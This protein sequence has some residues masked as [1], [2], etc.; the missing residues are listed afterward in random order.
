MTPVCEHA[1]KDANGYTHRCDRR[2]HDVDSLHVE[3]SHEIPR[4]D[5]EI[6]PYGEADCLSLGHHTRGPLCTLWNGGAFKRYVDAGFPTGVCR[7][8]DADIVFDG[9]DWIA[10]R[11]D[12]SACN[13]G[14]STM[15]PDACELEHLPS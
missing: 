15:H 7:F 13:E 5:C 10:Y 3:N 1:W 2:P 11:S 14:D 8:C 12:S 6:G 9:Q 4:T